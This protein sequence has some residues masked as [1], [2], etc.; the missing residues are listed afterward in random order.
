VPLGEHIRQRRE[1]LKLSQREAARILGVGLATL[2]NWERGRAKV[3]DSY[4]PRAIRFL[5]FDPNPVRSFPERIRAARHAAGLSQKA[6]ALRLGLD[7]STV[8]TWEAGRGESGHGRV[9]RV[10]EA[11]VAGEEEC[12]SPKV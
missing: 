1:D 7:P 11:F 3:S 12:G 6:V 8:R 4:Q 9:R 10:L 2:R 5:G